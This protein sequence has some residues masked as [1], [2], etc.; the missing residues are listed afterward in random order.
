M[1]ALRSFQTNVTKRSNPRRSESSATLAVRTTNHKGDIL[2]PVQNKIDVFKITVHKNERQKCDASCIS[3]G[4]N[5]Y[6]LMLVP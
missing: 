2:M 5:V 3:T 1:K 6:F 4:I